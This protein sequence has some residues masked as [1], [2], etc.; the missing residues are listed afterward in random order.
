MG[1]GADDAASSAVDDRSFASSLAARHL[2]CRDEERIVAH[3]SVVFNE[4]RT[5]A[6]VKISV[7]VVIARLFINLHSWRRRRSGRPPFGGDDFLLSARGRQDV[8][9]TDPLS[10]RE[11]VLMR[12]PP[13]FF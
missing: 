6:V 3:L 10:P 12:H 11:R 7:P 1:P 4:E 9:L 2:R 13:R 8:G 5:R